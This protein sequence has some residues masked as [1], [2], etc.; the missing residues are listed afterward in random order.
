MILDVDRIIRERD[1]ASIDKYISNILQYNFDDNE[2]N[3]LDPNF[4]KFIRLN[5]LST[6][7]LLFCKKYLDSTVTTLK[8]DLEKQ[9]KVIIN[10]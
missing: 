10:E 4:V 5:Q 6:E 2:M 7:Y 9:C 3:I 1:I 8:N